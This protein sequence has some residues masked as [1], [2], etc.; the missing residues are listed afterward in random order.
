MLESPYHLSVQVRASLRTLNCQRAIAGS[1]IPKKGLQT[2]CQP[3]GQ[4]LATKQIGSLVANRKL[5]AHMIC[6]WRR[7]GAQ[8]QHACTTQASASPPGTDHRER[9]ASSSLRAVSIGRSFNISMHA[10]APPRKCNC[11]ARS[12]VSEQS[13][14][15]LQNVS[16]LKPWIGDRRE[17]N[18]RCA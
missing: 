4:E 15:P 12:W 2:K 17:C 11:L 1:R 6:A 7:I 14:R 8:S 9:V 13:Q 16:V 5:A 3:H 18:F 10:R